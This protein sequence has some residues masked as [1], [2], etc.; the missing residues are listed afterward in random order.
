MGSWKQDQDYL[1]FHIVTYKTKAYLCRKTHKS[2]AFKDDQECWQ[3]LFDLSTLLDQQQN[4]TSTIDSVA[5]FE[6]ATLPKPELGKIAIIAD[7][8]GSQFAYGDGE[9]WWSIVSKKAC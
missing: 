5:V 2:K 6:K 4:N 1:P 3:G 7:Q 9:N 8:A